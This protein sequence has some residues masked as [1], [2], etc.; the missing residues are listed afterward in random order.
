MAGVRLHPGVRVLLG[1]ALIGVG[2]LKHNAVPLIVI[3]AVVGLLGIASVV[4]S[5]A[6]RDDGEGEERRERG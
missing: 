1:V 4:G 6:S 2:L 3:G 5:T